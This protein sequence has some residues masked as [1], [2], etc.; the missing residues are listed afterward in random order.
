MELKRNFGLRLKELRKSKKWTQDQLA[1]MVSV[2]TK[3][4][5]FLETGRSFPSADLLEKLR[6]IFQIDYKDIFDFEN[7][8]NNDEYITRINNIILSMD[9]NKVKFIYKMALELSGN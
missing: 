2:D 5:S 6:E 3:H 1:E 8:T 7:F 4:I 9:N